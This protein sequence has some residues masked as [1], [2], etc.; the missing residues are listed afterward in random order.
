[1]LATQDPRAKSDDDRWDKFPYYGN[2]A[3]TSK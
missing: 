3:K 2:P 1:M